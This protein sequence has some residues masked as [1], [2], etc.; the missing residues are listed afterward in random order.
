MD[1]PPRVEGWESGNTGMSHSSLGVSQDVSVVTD[2]PHSSPASWTSLTDLV[3]LSGVRSVVGEVGTGVGE[4]TVGEVM[5]GIYCGFGD[6]LINVPENLKMSSR[7]QRH[8]WLA[9]L[10][11]KRHPCP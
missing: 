11:Q 8:E 9:L 10:K 2:T 4:D 7:W 6:D 1:A 5:A 3:V